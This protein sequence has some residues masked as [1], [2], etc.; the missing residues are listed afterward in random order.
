MCL[1]CVCSISGMCLESVRSVSGAYLECVWKKGASLFGISEKLKPKIYN[2]AKSKM[3]W[4]EKQ[5]LIIWWEANSY[6]GVESDSNF[7]IYSKPLFQVWEL[8]P[9]WV[10]HMQP[11]LK[12]W[13]TIVCIKFPSTF[14]LGWNRRK[15]KQFAHFTLNKQ[16]AIPL[17]SSVSNF[18]SILWSK[19]NKV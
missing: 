1:E 16:H 5:M 18:I 3:W 10:S 8:G 4:M 15:L 6:Y 12:N 13:L 11:W 14:P 17:G 9:T 7:L 2:R 19:Y